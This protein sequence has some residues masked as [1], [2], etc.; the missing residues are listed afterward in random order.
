MAIKHNFV[1]TK[2]DSPDTSLVR[3]T[4]WNADHTLE[5]DTVTYA[6]MQNVSATDKI[7][8]RSTAGA[9]DIEEI[10][11]T[12]F[13][14]SIIDDAD[15]ATF[16]ATVNLEAGVD[17]QA[18][19]A[20]LAAIAGLVSAADKGIQFTGIGTAAT[21]DLTTAGKALLDDA[22]AAAQL[23]TLGLTATAAELNVLDGIT[24]TVTELNY[25]DGVTSA[26]QTQLDGKQASLG[27]TAE[28]SANKDASDGYTGLTLFKINFKNALNTIISFFTNANTVA[29]TYTFQDRDG[30]IADDTDLATK[31]ASDQDLTDLAAAGRGTAAQVYTSNGA[32]SAPTW[33]A[34]GG[35]AAKNKGKVWIAHGDNVITFPT[36]HAN[37]NYI[38]I[39]TLVQSAMGGLTP[40]NVRH[41]DGISIF[42]SNESTT[43]GKVRLEGGYGFTSC[44]YT[45]AG[46]GTTER[47]DDV[48]NTHTARTDAA[49]RYDVSGYS[50]NGYGFTSCGYT[51]AGVGT[52][53]RF[54]DVA[55]THT[56]RTDAT[57][58]YDVAGY[59]L[60]GYGF[61]SCGYTTAGV[62][63]TERFDDVANTHTART[64]ATA[65]YAPAGYSLNGYGF[66]SCGYTTA[67]AGTT[68]RFDDI[69]NTHTARTDAAARRLAAGYSLNEYFINYITME[70]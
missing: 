60:N 38:F 5:N 20:E 33:Q 9:G 17:V 15:E 44:G 2:T 67:N 23:V 62:G 57:A 27:Y 21:Y 56:A 65:R 10:A 54:D 45:T 63:T 68:E 39:A 58:R 3:K 30:T 51:T 46:V 41:I 47:F 53:E 34:G 18:Y 31:Q 28:N 7:L 48:A 40:R 26:I 69:A 61:T 16:K 6:K 19:D 24:P 4:E 59:S 43:R 49:A 64:D 13:A 25:T 11:C 66:T 1:S 36:A 55:N 22:N 8:G 35:A 42:V 52:T 32:A 37:N 29:R 50:L 14:R 12:L 70:A